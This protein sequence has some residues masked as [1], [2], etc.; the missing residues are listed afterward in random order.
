[1]GALRNFVIAPRFGETLAVLLE[2]PIILTLSWFVATWCM[3][4][5]EVPAAPLAR[6]EMGGVAFALLMLAEMSVALI[7]F[8]R[9]V[10]QHLASYQSTDGALGLGGQVAFAWIPLA[11]IWRNWNVLKVVR[12]CHTA[13]YVVMA[14]STFVLLYAG[15]TGT[16][17][18]WLWVAAALVG[19]E[20]IVF[21][22]NGLKC[23]LTAVAAKY[24][25]RQGSDTFLPTR[26]TRYTF[27]VF[28]PLILIATA[29][30]AVRWERWHLH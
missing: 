10:S 29:L 22:G 26:I 13:I 1:M 5:F 28:C 3:K 14:T 19:V 23:P 7:F 4:R 2:I 18:A 17:G 11:L 6:L 16:R 8:R 15:I 21:L 25:A 27:R 20:S 24:G 30:L 9:S 12:A